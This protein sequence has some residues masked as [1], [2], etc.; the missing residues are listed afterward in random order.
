MT[1]DDVRR[2]RGVGGKLSSGIFRDL[3]TKP[4]KVVTRAADVLSKHGYNQEAKQLRGW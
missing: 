3:C 2:M 4:P 1:K